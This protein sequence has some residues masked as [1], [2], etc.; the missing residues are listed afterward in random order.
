MAFF[1]N[2]PRPSGVSGGF[3]T[4]KW[5]KWRALSTL[6]WG[7]SKG[8]VQVFSRFSTLKWG[9]SLERDLEHLIRKSDPEDGF[10][11]L[12]KPFKV[13]NEFGDLID[14]SEDF[15]DQLH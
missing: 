7:K 15:F 6:K 1:Q 5:G 9:K 13:L 12:T 3:S 2:F 14:F 11:S 10:F 4:P 8:F